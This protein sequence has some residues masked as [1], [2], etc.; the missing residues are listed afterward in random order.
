M[1]TATAAPGAVSQSSP[2]AAPQRDIAT[3][4]SLSTDEDVYSRGNGT[5]VPEPI[6]VVP[7]PWTLIGDV[8][9]ISFWTSAA[10]AEKLPGHAYSP[11][12]AGTDF[13]DPRGGKPVGG[14]GMIQIIRFRE[15]PVGPYD[16]MLIVPG[17]FDWSRD[18]PEGHPVVGRNPRITRVYVSQKH[19]CY[20]GRIHWNC[21]KHLARF[22][23]DTG[24][25]D[26]V[27]VKVYPH[28]T[29]GDLTESAPSTAPFFQTSFTPMS[30]LPP[31]PFATRWANYLGF[32]TT[33]TMPPLPPGQGSQGELPGTDRWCTV[34]PK[35]YSPQTRTGWFD[36][37]M[38]D[39]DEKLMG[40]YENFWPGLGRWQLGVKMENARLRFDDP[41]ETWQAKAR[42][43]L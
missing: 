42:A 27:R 23:W 30:Y 12:E 4:T 32:Q 37:S 9:C 20:N 29:A 11:L 41:L 14:L 36:M 8:Y 43:R 31:F 28:D 18:G 7:P 17:S 33:L 3:S 1:T 13:A 21:P 19:T 39:A 25:N 6:Q 16:E 38:R 35:Q 15:S 40:E 2:S 22:D 26:S 24:P 10:A 34:V 5:S